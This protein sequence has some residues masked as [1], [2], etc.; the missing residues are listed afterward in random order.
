MF[1]S[2]S[3]HAAS[4]AVKT[5]DGFEE[6]ELASTY[7]PK[8]YKLIG[9]GDIYAPKPY[10]FVGLGDICAPKLYKLI[11]FGDICAPKPYNPTVTWSQ[12]KKLNKTKLSGS[13]AIRYSDFSGF[14]Q[15]FGQ[16]WAP[17]PSRTTGL[18]L[19]CSSTRR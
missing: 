1:G 4:T 11:G 8:P 10:N 13:L 12:N 15:I 17:N 19:Q 7:S 16:T 3:K 14:Q 9:F 18:V 5:Y 6:E 2:R